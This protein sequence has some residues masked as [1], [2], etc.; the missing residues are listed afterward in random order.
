MATI[1]LILGGA[2]SGKSRFAQQLA[3]KVGGDDVLFVATAQADD[4]EMTRRIQKHRK[5]RPAGWETLEV[6]HNVGKKLT[7]RDKK[8]RVIL[9]D[10]LV[11]LVSNVLLNQGDE[12]EPETAEQGMRTEVDL[13]LKACRESAET[14]IIVSGEVGQ[15]LVPDNPLGRLFRDLLGWANQRIAAEASAVYLLVAGYAVE[16]K[17]LARSV[18]QAAAECSSFSSP[19]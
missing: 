4:G 5:S 12:P 10:C 18:E 15:G 2:R 6:A 19:D 1:N 13:L 9:I 7:E 16:V 8:N 14:V 3:E 17:S 11:L